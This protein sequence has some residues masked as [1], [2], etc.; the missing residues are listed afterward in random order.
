M[1]RKD[2]VQLHIEVRAPG[3]GQ[4]VSA[5]ISECEAN[6]RGER[7]GVVEDASKPGIRRREW[8][9][10]WITSQVRTCSGASHTVGDTRVVV[11]EHRIERYAGVYGR[12][13]R[14]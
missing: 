4:N 8:T 1:N 11:V 10:V 2:L 13:S 6:G 7:G 3:I 5:H 12:S 14:E 9:R